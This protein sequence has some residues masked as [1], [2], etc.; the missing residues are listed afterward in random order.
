MCLTTRTTC[1]GSPQLTSEFD[2]AAFVDG[3]SRHYTFEDNDCAYRL[4]QHSG[5]IALA[6]NVDLDWM[7]DCKVKGCAFG[8]L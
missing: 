5:N 8:W 7:K 6:L 2:G 1:G 3:S 4:C